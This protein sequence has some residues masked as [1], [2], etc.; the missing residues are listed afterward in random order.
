MLSPKGLCPFG[1]PVSP[2]P[3]TIFSR[4]P[5]G[6]SFDKLNSS[7]SS[8]NFVLIVGIPSC[9]PPVIGLSGSSV[10]PFWF[11][12]FVVF[13]AFSLASILTFNKSNPSGS[14]PIIDL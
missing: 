10:K 3:F 7:N 6:S 11:T 4:S 2:S 1:K 13:K 12:T 5:I 8:S 9:V 14:L